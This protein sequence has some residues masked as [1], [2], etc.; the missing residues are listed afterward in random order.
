MELFGL[1]DCNNFFCSC[2]RVFHPDLNGKPVVVLSNNDGCIIA[3]SNE[4]KALGLKMGQPFYQVKDQLEK[5]GVAVFSSNYNLYGDMSRR[6]MS[7]LSR[8]T[9]HLDIYSIDEAFLDFS[10]M[11]NTDQLGEYA[12]DMVRTIAKGTGIPVSVGIAPTKTL[13]KMASKYAKKYPDYHGVAIIDTLEKRHKALELFPIGDVWGIGRNLVKRMEQFGIHTAADFATKKPSWVQHE[14]NI[15][16]LRTW[17]ELNGQSCIQIE[18]LPQKQSICTSRSFPDAGLCELEQVEQAVANFATACTRKLREQH[19]VCGSI[20]VFA[21]TSRFR[22]DIEQ[23]C[24]YR[25][26]YFQVPTSNQ[27]EIVSAACGALRSE[28][29]TNHRYL[30]KKAGVIVWNISDAGSVQGDLF[31]T[32]DRSRME[33][34]MKA[35]DNINHKN[36]HD[37]LRTAVQGYSQQWHLKNEHKSRQYTTNLEQIITL[38][39]L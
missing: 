2:E 27:Q 3:R 13:A 9:P 24:I 16:G 22:T 18:T 19:S 38:K 28:W 37:T 35:V 1:A 8:Y 36:G 20:T 12:R 32:V 6:V 21:Y 4:A 29:D 39:A 11:G 34:L 14:F 30:Y 25:N 5:Q 15:T 26:V 23:N 31:D 7:L 33:A 17:K 10:G